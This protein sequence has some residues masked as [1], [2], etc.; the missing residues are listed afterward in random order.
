MKYEK[1]QDILPSEIIELIQSYIDGS[2]LYIPR[3]NTLRKSWGEE[4]GIK[5]TLSLRNIDIYSKY[6]NGSSIKELSN[7]YY[8]TEDSIRRIIRAEK[9]K[10]N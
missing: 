4:S 7:E 3:K 1:A 6:L 10:H 9:K 8:L 2:Y 5:K